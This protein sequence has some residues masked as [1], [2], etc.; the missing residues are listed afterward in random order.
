MAGPATL[1]RRS[2]SLSSKPGWRN[3]S[4]Y[5]LSLGKNIIAKSVVYG[6]DTYFETINFACVSTAL[7]SARPAA[8]IPSRSDSSWASIRRSYSSFGNLASIGSQTTCSSSVLPGR[9]IANSTCASLPGTV[10]TL[11][12][13][14]SGVIPSSIRR[15]NCTSPQ[16]PRVLTLVNTRFKSPTPVAR[17]C[18]SPSPLCTAS[19]RSDT[20]L[21]DSPSRNSS[22]ACSFSSTVRRISS[23][24]LALSVCNAS[25]RCSTAARNSVIR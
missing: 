16:V 10:L 9:R 5:R 11:R 15:A 1:T 2:W 12:P 7:P 23:S 24:L 20:C 17:V 22:V 21:N 14:C 19:S 8:L 3:T 4:A 25:K 18:I 13:Y 6:G